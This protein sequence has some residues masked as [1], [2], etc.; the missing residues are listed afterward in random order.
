MSKDRKIIQISIII[1][2]ALYYI[3]TFFT[4]YVRTAI[5]NK[6]AEEVDLILRIQTILNNVWLIAA[7]ALAAVILWNIVK[8][9]FNKTH[10]TS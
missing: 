3:N 9:L 10:F 7:P 4:M 2:L 6:Q 5:V 8:L 1:V